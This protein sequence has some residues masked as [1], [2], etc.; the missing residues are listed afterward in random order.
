MGNH[1]NYL[2]TVIR[3]TPGGS[4]QYT[5]THKQYTERQ[6]NNRTTQLTEQHN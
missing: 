3:L 2:L 1:S 4:I 6:I 5:F